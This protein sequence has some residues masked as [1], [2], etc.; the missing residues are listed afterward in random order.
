MK[1]H[2]DPRVVN[3]VK[4]T[5]VQLYNQH[6]D[7]IKTSWCM[8]NNIPLLRFWEEDIRKDSK[9]VMDTLKA[10]MNSITHEEERNRKISGPHL[11][12]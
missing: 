12:Y 4:L 10:F 6:I 9:K 7:K 11:T 1:W 8:R 5:K 2:G 3:E